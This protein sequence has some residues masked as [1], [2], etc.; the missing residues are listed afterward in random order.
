[1]LIPLLLS[2][3]D[4]EPSLSESFLKIYDDSDL[5]VTYRP[6]DVVETVDG[7]IVLAGTELSKSDFMGV[8][9]MKMDKEGNFEYDS[10]LTDYVVPVGN[11]YLNETDSNS[12]FFV[13]NPTSLEAVLIGVNPQLEVQTETLIGGL[14]Y[15]L[16]S[17]VLSNGNFLL[18]SYDPLTQETEISE[19]SLDGSFLGGNSYSIGPGDDVEEEI[20]NHYLNASERPLPF[21]CGEVSSG[22]Y[23]FNGFYNYSFS[24]VFTDFGDAPNGVV[25]GQSSNAGLRAVM[26]ISGSDFAVA[27]F[28]FDA[29]FQL[30]TATLST[31]GTTSSVDLFTGNMAEIKP[32]TPTQIIN[33]NNGSSYSV[34]ASETKGRQI[35]LNFYDNSGAISGVHRIGHIN[36]FTF[37]SIKTGSDNSLLVLG[38]TFVAERFE[39]IALKKISENEISA[40][41]N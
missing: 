27:G 17:A 22:N 38:T 34:F 8:K 1:M 13:M 18:Q 16:S 4:D 29:N 32:Y 14:N 28:Q 41:L 30:A 7:F 5:D 40:F 9:L 24:L 19:V 6:I 21:F 25:Q 23:Y 35:L 2:C 10:D 3:A 15:P 31:G 39:R 36:P 11:M 26:P 20:I 37:A 33:Y 12:Y